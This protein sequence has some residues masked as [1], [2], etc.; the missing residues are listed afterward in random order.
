[1]ISP[2]SGGLPFFRITPTNTWLHQERGG[3]EK[4]QHHCQRGK[5]SAALESAFGLGPLDKIKP[6]HVASFL[7]K[8]IQAGISKRTVKLDVITLRNVLK[9][10]RDIEQHI[11]ALPIPLG[12]N[13]E[14]KSATPKRQLFTND[15]LESLCQAALARKED[16]MVRR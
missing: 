6:A 9:R 7:K 8:R 2:P 3:T 1:M 15:Q 5:P 13:G 14:L 4:T 11:K 16:R 12:L 10:A